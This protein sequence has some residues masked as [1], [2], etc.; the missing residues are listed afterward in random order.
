M[1][2][3]M[4]ASAQNNQITKFIVEPIMVNMMNI[5]VFLYFI[6]MCASFWKMLICFLAISSQTM[7]KLAVVFTRRLPFVTA[8]NRA[9][10]LFKIFIFSRSERKLFTTSFAIA[11]NFF[12][13]S[14]FIGAFPR[15]INVFA[16]FNAPFLGIKDV[17]AYAT[18]H[19][20]IRYGSFFK[21]YNQHKREFI[22]N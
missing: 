3:T 9:I 19:F 14:S 12:F 1:M 17:F 4:T 2:S 15:T 16:S 11:F 22:C 13:R 8:Y 10:Y 7:N 20:H 5:H 21:C 18:G 6:A